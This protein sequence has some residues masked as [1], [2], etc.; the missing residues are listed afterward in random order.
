M[1]R[2]VTYVK[3]HVCERRVSDGLCQESRSYKAG[4]RYRV[5]EFVFSDDSKPGLAAFLF[6]LQHFTDMVS[7]RRA[8]ATSIRGTRR[9]KA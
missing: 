7:N 8:P 1:S 6:T 3:T 5:F 4:E 9:L 2:A